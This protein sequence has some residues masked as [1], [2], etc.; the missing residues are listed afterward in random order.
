[1]I[2]KEKQI[3]IL[4][5]NLPELGMPEDIFAINMGTSST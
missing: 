1:M 4:H 5:K 3:I 2:E